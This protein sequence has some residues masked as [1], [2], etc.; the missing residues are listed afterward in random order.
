MY[1]TPNNG[2]WPSVTPDVFWQQQQQPPVPPMDSSHPSAP[3][4]PTWPNSSMATPGNHPPIPPYLLHGCPGPF[5]NNSFASQYTPLG[6]FPSYPSFPTNTNILSYPTFP[7]NSQYNSFPQLVASY[8]VLQPP[9]PGFFPYIPPPYIPPPVVNNPQQNHPQQQN[10]HNT[11]QNN[12]NHLNNVTNTVP[13]TYNQYS[14][15]SSFSSNSSSMPSTTSIMELMGGVPGPIGSMASNPLRPFTV[16][17]HI[18][19]RILQILCHQICYVGLCILLSWMSGPLPRTG[20]FTL[21]GRSKM[22]S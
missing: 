17:F 19:L 16:S 21:R 3:H 1:W 4:P 5:L 11:N 15:T 12:N 7:L 18:F 20:R 10:S 8:H 22:L 9:P 2:K 13:F 6:P 14:T